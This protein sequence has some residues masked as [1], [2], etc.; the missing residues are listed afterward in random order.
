[1]LGRLQSTLKTLLAFKTEAEEELRGR[2]LVGERKVKEKKTELTEIIA[3]CH[4]ELLQAR[5]HVFENEARCS[6]QT[7][8]SKDCIPST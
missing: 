5:E 2:R 8:Q 7:K 1:M 3:R 4:T 6:G